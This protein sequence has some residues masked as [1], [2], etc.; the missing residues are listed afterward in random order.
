MN[1]G[2]SQLRILLIEDDIDDY[3]FFRDALAESGMKAD[4]KIATR[5]NHILDVI[6]TSTK[7]LPDIIFLDLHMQMVSGHE[8]L[9][10][11][12]SQPNLNHV[13]VVIYSTS[14]SSFDIEATFL[15]GANLYFTKPSSFQLLVAALKK[16]LQ[17]DWNNF[18]KERNRL[19]Y[20]FKH[21]VLN[22]AAA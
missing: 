17:L 13:P 6:G 1:P 5:C 14:A 15:G 12:R 2:N 20:V 8:C 11:I 21:A 10:T 3:M 22:Q 9:Q 18:S 16:I 19:N 7:S 4:L